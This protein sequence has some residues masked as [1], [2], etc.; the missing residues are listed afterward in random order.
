MNAR[1]TFSAKGQIVIPKDVRDRYRFTNGQVVDVV[2]MPEGVLLRAPAQQKAS[3]F[4]EAME[5]MRQAIDYRGPRLD[6]E[7]WQ[8]GIAKAIR[9]KWSK[10]LP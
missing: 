10:R 8:A 1:A 9:A 5:R 2:E 3:S 7:D 6:E 4:D